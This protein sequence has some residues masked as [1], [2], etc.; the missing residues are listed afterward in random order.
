M[1]AA[2]RLNF[3]LPSLCTQVRYPC[4]VSLNMSFKFIYNHIMNV[5]LSVTFVKPLEIVHRASLA[6]HLPP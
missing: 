4:Q 3:L 2:M 6:L 5:F 1:G